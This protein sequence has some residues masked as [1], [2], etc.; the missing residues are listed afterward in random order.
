MRWRGLFRLRFSFL[1]KRGFASLAGHLAFWAWQKEH[2][3][4]WSDISISWWLHFGQAEDNG[5]H[6]SCNHLDD[7]DYKRY[8]AIIYPLLVK[9]NQSFK[10]VR[11]RGGSR[12]Q[13]HPRD[14][15]AVRPEFL[16]IR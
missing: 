13:H 3:R 16:A 9:D 1:G 12:F 11:L 2:G 6:R 5:W 8:N 14:F 10:I 4:S 15:H 7:R